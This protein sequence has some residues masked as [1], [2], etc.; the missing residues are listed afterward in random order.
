MCFAFAHDYELSEEQREDLWFYIRH[1]D[2]AF[3]EWWIKRQP[4]PKQ[5]RIRGSGTNPS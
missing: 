3:M 2:Q 4:K 1:M 5:P